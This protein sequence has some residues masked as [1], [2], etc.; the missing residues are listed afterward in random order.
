MQSYIWWYF[1][2]FEWQTTSSAALPWHSWRKIGRQTWNK[3]YKR[4]CFKPISAL[5]RV[6]ASSLHSYFH[7][8]QQPVTIPQDSLRGCYTSGGKLLL[9]W[10]CL[11][12]QWKA[13]LPDYEPSPRLCWAIMQNE[14][15]HKR[16]ILSS[17]CISQ[18]SFSYCKPCIAPLSFVSCLP[19]WTVTGQKQFPALTRAKNVKHSL[20][21]MWMEKKN[22]IPIKISSFSLIYANLAISIIYFDIYTIA[23][24]L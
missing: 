15:S 21:F 7:W 6:H 10:K 4:C 1:Y 9:K 20:K 3:K 8:H 18:L 16:M 2:I 13:P 23:L 24:C 12:T 17:R 19:G 22:T 14:N 5:A 11:L